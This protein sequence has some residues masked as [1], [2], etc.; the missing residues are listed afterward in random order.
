M[1]RA[2]EKR[3]ARLNFITHLQSLIPYEEIVCD[4]EVVSERVGLPK[5]QKPKGYTE[6]VR[7]LK[8]VP[9]VF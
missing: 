9:D 7:H 2:D 5:R 3:R 6:P 8:Y 4:E 1:V